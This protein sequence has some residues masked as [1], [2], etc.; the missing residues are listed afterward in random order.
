MPNLHPSHHIH[1]VPGIYWR[2]LELQPLGHVL[3]LLVNGEAS[4]LQRQ[5]SCHPRHHRPPLDPQPRRRPY[6]PSATISGTTCVTRMSSIT[7]GFRV[8]K[9]PLSYVLWGNDTVTNNLAAFTNGSGD[10]NGCYL[11]TTYSGV[12]GVPSGG[13]MAITVA[14]QDI[15]PWF[16]NIGINDAEQCNLDSCNEHI[17]QGGGQPHLHGDPFGTNCLYSAANYSSVDAHP[18]LTGFSLDGPLIFGR[19]L[20]ISAPGYN[21]SLDNCGGHSHGSYGYH[22]H[23][24]IIN[25]TAKTGVAQ[26]ESSHSEWCSPLHHLQLL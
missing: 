21:T 1:T 20:S 17:G 13:N 14:G 19:Y 5:L 15:Y 4:L 7:Q 3:S 18:P 10:C 11:N 8:T 12:L 24:F 22:Y 26:G 25:D 16:N 6:P 23:N 2:L 9:V